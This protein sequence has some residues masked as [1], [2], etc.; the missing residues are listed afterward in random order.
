MVKAGAFYMK[1]KRHQLRGTKRQWFSKCGLG[2][3]GMASAS[4][5]KLLDTQIL[6]PHLKPT[7]WG[8]GVEASSLCF[9]KPSGKFQCLSLRI[10]R[11]R[12]S[13]EKRGMKESEA[14]TLVNIKSPLSFGE[15]IPQLLHCS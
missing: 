13:S 11:M 2:T 15:G 9:N 10:T 8:P 4:A 3:R 14:S 12:K 5:G 1:K 6:E 7:E